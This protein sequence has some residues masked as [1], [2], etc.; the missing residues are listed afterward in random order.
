MIQTRDVFSAINQLKQSILADT[1]MMLMQFKLEEQ[2][3]EKRYNRIEQNYKELK[4]KTGTLAKQ[5][6]QILS[7]LRTIRLDGDQFVPVWPMMTSDDII[8]FN[9]DLA[10]PKYRNN[11][12][13]TLS[14]E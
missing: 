7:D 2:H 11:V 12:V 13:N 9:Q 5:N 14:T 8:Q 10:H 3:I 1:K 6:A 4:S